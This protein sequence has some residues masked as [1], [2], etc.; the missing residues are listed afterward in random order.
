MIVGLIADRQPPLPFTG[1]FNEATAS[2]NI[3]GERVTFADIALKSSEMKINGNGWLDL[4]QREVS[5]DF[6]TASSGK[7][8]PSGDRSPARCG[9]QRALSDQGARQDQRTPGL[10]GQ[11]PDD[12]DDRR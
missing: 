8:F 11:L 7:R 2:Y 1:G 4:G 9:S 6:Y 12:H 5:L 3:D 10:G